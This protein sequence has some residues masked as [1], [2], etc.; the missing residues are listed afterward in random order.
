MLL[1]TIITVIAVLTKILFDC[2]PKKLDEVKL[3]VILWQEDAQ[4]T[5]SLNGFLDKRFLLSEIRLH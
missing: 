4:V 3:T 1:Q 2:T 5:S